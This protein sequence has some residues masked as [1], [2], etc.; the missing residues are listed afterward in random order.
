MLLLILFLSIAAHWLALSLLP[1]RLTAQETETEPL[2]LDAL[3]AT[4]VIWTPSDEVASQRRNDA[5][6]VFDPTLIAF[7][8]E[9]GFAHRVSRGMPPITYRPQLQQQQPRLTETTQF[10]QTRAPV[11]ATVPLP[12]ELA[13][14]WTKLLPPPQA[15]DS[16]LLPLPTDPPPVLELRGTLAN[17]PLL[18]GF[19]IPELAT[20]PAQPIRFEIAV[21]NDGKVRSVMLKNGGSGNADTDRLAADALSR[22]ILAPTNVSPRPIGIEPPAASQPNLEWG[23]AIIFWKV[24][25]KPPEQ[26]NTP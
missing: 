14:R 26:P 2:R 12:Q 8:N 11:V 22:C 23:E 25:S 21:D 1:F 5:M 18:V 15:T 13:A 3:R 10:A 24:K 19:Q 6:A 4:V 20:P 16:L 7:S 9:R 17:R